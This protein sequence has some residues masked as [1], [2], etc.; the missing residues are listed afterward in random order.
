MLAGIAPGAS[1]LRF[2]KVLRT[3]GSGSSEDIRR[4]MDYLSHPTSCTYRG[5][6]S[7]A[8]KPLIVNMS[9]GAASLSFSGRGV[10]ERKLDS[11]VHAHSQLYVVAQANRADQGFS[12]Y[13]TAKN[14]LSVGAV[15]D[16]GRI[17]G[18]SSHGPTAD[19]RIAPNVWAR[20]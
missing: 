17:A 5:V 2:G 16:T 8:A 6:R 12:N 15:D 19:G 3:S 18:F 1:H 13:G 9:L 7:E 4:G 11:V 14:S 10:G 20:A